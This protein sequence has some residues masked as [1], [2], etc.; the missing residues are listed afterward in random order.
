MKVGKIRLFN[1][2]K[3]V[4]RSRDILHLDLSTSITIGCDERNLIS[5]VTVADYVTRWK[6]HYLCLLPGAGVALAVIK[7]VF[8]LQQMAQ[9]YVLKS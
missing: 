2:D 9:A 6:R 5:P 3:D 4:S 1:L 8:S 7:C